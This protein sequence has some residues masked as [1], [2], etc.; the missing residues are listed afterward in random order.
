MTMADALADIALYEQ[1]LACPVWRG[2]YDIRTSGQVY[3]RGE[4][5][6]QM[7][8]W[9]WAYMLRLHDNMPRILGNLLAH[10]QAR[11]GETYTEDLMQAAGKKYFTLAQYKS[12]YARIPTD[13][14]VKHP[15]A[16]HTYCRIVSSL[17]KDEPA[18]QDA[19]LTRIEAGE[20]DESDSDGTTKEQRIRRIVNMLKGQ[21]AP[22]PE[23]PLYCPIC[24][25]NNGKGWMRSDLLKSECGHCGAHGDELAQRLAD[26]IACVR[27]FYRTGDR[28]PLN[29]F[30]RSYK[31]IEQEAQ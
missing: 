11:W 28:E 23:Q 27:E 3:T 26:L 30:V 15:D 5:P 8:E 22:K 6:K 13:V 12:T 10:S 1:G 14:Q 21:P 7:F 24:Y 31:I 4:P 2:Y 29:V 9:A 17:G 18:Q 20:F 25:S 19:I 16:K